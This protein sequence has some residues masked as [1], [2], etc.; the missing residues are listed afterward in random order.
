MPHDAGM[1]AAFLLSGDERTSFGRSSRFEND[2]AEIGQLKQLGMLR[3][4]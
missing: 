1:V 2:K 3:H 4:G